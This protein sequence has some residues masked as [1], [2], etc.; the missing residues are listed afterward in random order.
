M[1]CAAQ[2]CVGLISAM[3][4]LEDGQNEIHATVSMGNNIFEGGFHGVS[5]RTQVTLGYRRQAWLE[6]N[7][8]LWAVT[9]ES[10]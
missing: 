10:R 4:A 2:S 7:T 8:E 1:C 3:V 5:E 9:D 6:Q